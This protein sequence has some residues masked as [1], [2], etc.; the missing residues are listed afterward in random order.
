MC[1][2]TFGTHLIFVYYKYIVVGNGFSQKLVVIKTLAGIGEIAKISNAERRTPKVLD[3]PVGRLDINFAVNIFS[4]KS[5]V[6][7]FFNEISSEIF[8]QYFL[9]QLSPM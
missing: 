5:A 1:S 8:F 9:L 4:M 3:R 2:R 6:K 7:I